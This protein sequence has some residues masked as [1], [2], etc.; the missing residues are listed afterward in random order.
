MK[1]KILIII[2]ILTV[3]VAGFFYFRDGEEKQNLETVEERELVEEVFETGVVKS[4]DLL[5]LSFQ[6][7][8]TVTEM[9]VAE[10]E[11]ISE[12]DLIA[13]LDKRDLMTGVEKARKQMEA[14]K[15]E[16][17][18]VKQGGREEEIRSLENR[19][20][21]AEQSL[22]IAEKSLEEAKKAKET[23]LENA[24]SGTPS[25]VNK[26]Y[27]LSKS[28][29]DGYKEVRDRYFTGI[30]LQ[31]TYLARNAIRTIEN[32]YED[33]RD[34]SRSLTTDS[35]H[36]EMGRA[37]LQAEETFSTIEEAIE[38]VIEVSEIDFYENRFTTDTNEYLWE[39]KSDASDMLASIVAKKGE[40]ESVRDS[41][42]SALTSAESGVASARA[43]RNE[44]EDNLEN[45]K[46]GGRQSQIDAAR[47]KVEAAKTD[48]ALALRNLQRADLYSPA[49]GKITTVHHK[50]SEE[51]SPGVPVV[52]LLT[53]GNFYIEADIYEGEITS[54]NIG[55]PVA[56]EL[57]PFPGEEFSGEIV[58]INETGKV[59]DGVVY[60]EVDISLEDA[61]ERLMPEM[62]ADVTI[63]TSRKTTLSL[64]R[65]AIRRDGARRYVKAWEDGKEREIDIEVGITDPYG[66]VEIVSG[67]SEGDRAIVE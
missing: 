61:P 20:E 3:G 23:N 59:V 14:A 42:D 52:T 55:D 12:G 36:E 31:D 2:I 21:D 66:Y 40:I 51:V 15:A 62:T 54:V 37:L 67:L 47:A 50:R 35:T 48:L 19:L 9:R 34:T 26:A 53:E 29:K 11:A 5:N 58:S 1:K 57:V 38:T 64:P 41:A 60:Y 22:E 28:L 65:D 25:L 44:I 13:S 18:S 27:L 32:S 17:E 45:L 24:Y 56:I 43:R 7:G 46:L 10:G 63:E 4:G 6:S 33:L 30:Y 8:G 16:L 39:S 49:G